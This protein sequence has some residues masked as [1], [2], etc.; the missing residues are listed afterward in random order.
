MAL[1]IQAN[2]SLTNEQDLSSEQEL[3]EEVP[4]HQSL[5]ITTA[6]ITAKIPHIERRE[7]DELYVRRRYVRI[8]I[9]V[10][11]AKFHSEP[12]LVA[13]N[14]KRREDQKDAALP[15]PS[16]T[17]K[18]TVNQSTN[19]GGNGFG[20][21]GGGNGGEEGGDGDDDRGND[22]GRDDDLE[23]AK[24]DGVEDGQESDDEFQSAS[25][26]PWPE[27]AWTDLD[28]LERDVLPNPVNISAALE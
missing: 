22:H 24:Y 25:S 21:N 18:P 3:I 2:I 1:S 13:A 28:S 26:T 7:V 8:P 11:P 5:A 23:P 20:S 9:T 17:S 16:C 6:N 10:A 19:G 12:R 4:L 27:D 14:V 15:P